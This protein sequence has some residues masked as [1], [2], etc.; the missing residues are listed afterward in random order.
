MARHRPYT[1]PN[2]ELARGRIEALAETDM[3]RSIAVALA[4]VGISSLSAVVCAADGNPSRGQRVFNACAPCHSLVPNQNMT[5]PS[6]AG[7]WNR[8]AGGL[9]NSSRYSA[10]MKSSAIVWND[11][12]LEEW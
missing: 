3:S 2:N 8:M 10:P 5:G 9:A 1:P 4:V 11:K 12:T 7:L 6:L